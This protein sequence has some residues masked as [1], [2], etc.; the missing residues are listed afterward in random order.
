MPDLWADCSVSKNISYIAYKKPQLSIA[1][2]LYCVYFNIGSYAAVIV[3]LAEHFRP[4]V[5][6]RFKVDL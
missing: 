3:P 2:A 4:S 1:A 6:E 5:F